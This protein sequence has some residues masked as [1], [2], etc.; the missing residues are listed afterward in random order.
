[1]RMRTISG[2]WARG[3]EGKEKEGR[4]REAERGWKGRTRESG[5]EVDVDG[6]FVAVFRPIN[7]LETAVAFY[8]KTVAGIKPDLPGRQRGGKVLSGPGLIFPP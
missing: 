8:R 5:K 1:M 4:G 7:P 3:G 6:G 2:N